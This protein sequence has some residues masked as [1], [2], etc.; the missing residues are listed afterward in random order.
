[1]NT[2]RENIFAS[3]SHHD[4]QHLA[5][6]RAEAKAKIARQNASKLAAASSSKSKTRAGS[7][8]AKKS[9]EKARAKEKAK[10]VVGRDQYDYCHHCKQLKNVELLVRCKYST[11][12]GNQF[13][14][15]PYEPQCYTVNGC[16]ILNTDP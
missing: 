5:A 13:I 11:P 9:P 6:I 4:M 2:L 12:A 3:S 15:Y 1:M 16:R 8:P 14:P 10:I 7:Q